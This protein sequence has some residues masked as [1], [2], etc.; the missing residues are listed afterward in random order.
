VRGRPAVD[1]VLI[2]SGDRLFVLTSDGARHAVR[3]PP[4]SLRQHLGERVWVT[5]DDTS[6]STAYGVLQGRR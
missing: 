4:S 5:V 1:G 6:A 2:A 3:R